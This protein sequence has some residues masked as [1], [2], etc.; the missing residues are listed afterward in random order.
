MDA[1]LET[2]FN[3]SSIDDPSIQH[4]AAWEQQYHKATHNPTHKKKRSINK[5]RICYTQLRETGAVKE[6]SGYTNA[7]NFLIVS[8]N[9]GFLIRARG[10]IIKIKFIC[11][12]NQGM[13]YL[14]T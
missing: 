11:S 9:I 10:N 7:E 8:A 13:S 5:L 2:L 12:A 1:S 3:S 14:A 4:Y 6:T